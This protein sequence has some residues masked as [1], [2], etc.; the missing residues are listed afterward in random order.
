MSMRNVLLCALLIALGPVAIPAVAQ[1]NISINLG[2]APPAPRYEVVPTPRSGYAWAPGYW[3]WEGERHVW[4]QGRWIE[5]RPGSYWVADR[6]EA[7]DGRHYYESG[8][9]KQKAKLKKVKHEGKGNGKG[10][11]KGHDR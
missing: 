2:V 5:A 1:I 4:A 11:A 3:R 7:R 9:W 8:H 10:W 6:W